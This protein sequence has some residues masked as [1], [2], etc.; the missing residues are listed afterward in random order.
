MSLAGISTDMPTGF[1]ELLAIGVDELRVRHAIYPTAS[2][3]LC[4]ALDDALDVHGGANESQ[5]DCLPCAT[6]AAAID[7]ID[8]SAPASWFRSGLEEQAA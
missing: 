6:A 8:R 3:A 1:K 7:K 4:G 2:R 5:P